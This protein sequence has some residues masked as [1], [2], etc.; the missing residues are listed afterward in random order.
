M[1]IRCTIILVPSN[2]WYRKLLPSCIFTIIPYA[3]SLRRWDTSTPEKRFPVPPCR[4]PCYLCWK[5]RIFPALCLTVRRCVCFYQDSRFRGG[6]GSGLCD[7]RKWPVSYML[8]TRN[9]F[10]LYGLHT[11]AQRRKWIWFPRQLNPLFFFSLWKMNVF[12]CCFFMVP[13]FQCAV[14]SAVLEVHK[15]TNTCMSI[16]NNG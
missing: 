7:N 4:A 9:M 11:R 13:W 8:I 16:V 3:H 1:I 5:L 12:C 2:S 10:R 15:C 6:G 14:N